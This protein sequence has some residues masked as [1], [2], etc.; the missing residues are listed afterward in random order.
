[1]GLEVTVPNSSQSDAVLAFG[2]GVVPDSIDRLR[3]ILVYRITSAGEVGE[4]VLETYDNTEWMLLEINNRTMIGPVPLGAEAV[5]VG[6]NSKVIYGSNRDLSF[7]MFS[8]DGEMLHIA[9]QDCCDNTPVIDEA[10][11]HRIFERIGVNYSEIDGETQRLLPDRW[12]VMDTFVIDQRGRIWTSLNLYDPQSTT[13]FL[14]LDFDGDVIA[15]G[16]LNERIGL[17]HVTDEYLYGV[18]TDENNVD[19]IVKYRIVSGSEDI[20]YEGVE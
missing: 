14:I 3:R 8:M 10:V 20:S 11:F 2:R 18:K 13:F 1:L 6:Y 15:R 17:R 5:M 9:R 12:P 7:E 19:T 16:E 4:K